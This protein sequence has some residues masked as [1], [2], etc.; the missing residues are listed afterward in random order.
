MNSE[1]FLVRTRAALD[2]WFVP[3]AIVLVALSLVSGWAVF[4]GLAETTAEHD[5]QTVELWS[6][7]AG[8]D[9]SAEVQAENEVF[10]VGEELTRQEMY[11]GQIAPTLEGEFAHRYDAADG[12]VDV[13]V[14]LERQIRAVEDDVVYWST[15]EP[16]EEST[17]TGVDPGDR[18][19]VEF[20]V[21][22]PAL[23]NESERVAASIGDTPGSV[24]TA[25]V[26]DV[27][28]DGT[29]E[30][31][32][33]QWSEQYELMIDPDGD[34]YRV[35]GPISDRYTAEGTAQVDGPAESSVSIPTWAV[36]LFVGS[37]TALGVLTA[38]KSQDRLAPP[39]ATLERLA[40]EQERDSL[41]EWIT[42]G[43][44]PGEVRERSQI[45]VDSLEG[46]VDVAIDCD[47]RV[48][49]DSDDQRTY[50][51]VDGDMLYVY[52]QEDVPE[53]AF[54]STEEDVSFDADD[55]NDAD[56]FDGDDGVSFDADE[57]GDDDEF[58]G[59]ESEQIDGNDE[60]GDDEDSR[61]A[62]TDDDSGGPNGRESR[63]DE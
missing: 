17:A 6:A 29:I 59:D 30:G 9:H 61:S 31:E 11:F 15:S 27:R 45:P 16:L 54:D 2:T 55:T 10:E 56:P 8:F 28:M 24:E 41:D 35:E 36:F 33:V 19:T 49:E 4:A 3:V 18:Q 23:E 5:E 48:I 62:S 37:I 60:S 53:T 57:T 58:T 38:R 40:V 63:D 44:L 21:D 43:S 26:A 50:Y 46:L 51:V 20:A 32:P 52:E 7:T 39:Q 42:V 14:T 1:Q 25:V 13:H 12:D 34:V 22:V 47:R